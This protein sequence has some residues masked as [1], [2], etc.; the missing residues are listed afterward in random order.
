MY[1]QGLWFVPRGWFT[2]RGV[3][4]I[5]RRK[6]LTTAKSYG[7]A[8]LYVSWDATVAIPMTAL[9]AISQIKGLVR[10][11]HFDM[12]VAKMRRELAHDVF[13]AVDQK[14]AP[15]AGLLLPGQQFSLVGMG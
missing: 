2:S 8:T 5:A 15:C 14:R 9:P 12:S 7:R 10:Q 1:W 13:F 6:V 11:R 4:F 3:L